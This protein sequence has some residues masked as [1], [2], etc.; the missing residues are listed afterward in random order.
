MTDD[1]LENAVSLMQLGHDLL[2]EIVRKVAEFET[3]LRRIDKRVDD[4]ARVV[5]P[6]CSGASSGTRTFAG[7]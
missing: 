5:L 1:E 2:P 7:C 6:A 4:I 3:L